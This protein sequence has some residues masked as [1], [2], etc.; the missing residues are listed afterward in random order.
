LKKL[1]IAILF[2]GFACG[3]YAGDKEGLQL[4]Q[5]YLTERIGRLQA[6]YVIAQEQLKEVNTMIQNMQKEETKTRAAQPKQGVK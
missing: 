6:E 1:F 2:I 4:K 5:A 3:A